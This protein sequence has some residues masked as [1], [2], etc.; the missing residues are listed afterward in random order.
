ME[1]ATEQG[2]A[3]LGVEMTLDYAGLPLNLRFLL[4]TVKVIAI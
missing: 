4:L 2:V 3:A 1:T